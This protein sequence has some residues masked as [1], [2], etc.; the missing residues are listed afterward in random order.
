MA[1]LNIQTNDSDDSGTEQEPSS[2]ARLRRV[3]SETSPSPAV[4]FS[5]DKENRNQLSRRSSGLGKRKN[6]SGLMSAPSAGRSAT[7]NKRR[8]LESQRQALPSQAVHRRELEERVDKQYYDPDQ[9]EE[10]RRANRKLMRDVQKNLNGSLTRCWLHAV[11][12]LITFQIRGE[13]PSKPIL[14]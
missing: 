3:T 6:A 9:N 8:R 5:S 1:R 4:S 2:P 7:S 12:I 10:E 14:Q 13:K 11:L